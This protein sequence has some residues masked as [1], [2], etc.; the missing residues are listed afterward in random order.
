MPEVCIVVPAYRAESTL[1]AALRSVLEQS[2]RDWECVVVDDAS[3]DGTADA[4]AG[5][6]AGDPR[7][8]YSRLDSNRGPAAARNRGIALARSPWIAFLDGD[9]AWVPWRLEAGLVLAKQDPGIGLWCGETA[10]WSGAES[11]QPPARPSTWPPAFREVFLD[12]LAVH[13]PVATSTVLARREVLDSV[14]GFDEGF[15]GPEDYDLWL[16]VAGRSRLARIAA[17]LC[18]YRHRPGSLSLNDTRF[19]VEI[20]RVI[21]KAYGPAGVLAGRPGR[22]RALAYYVFSCCWMA[23]ERGDRARAM[24]LFW[25]GFWLW[26]WSHRNPYTNFRGMRTR[27]LVYV[28]RR[29]VAASGAE[30]CLP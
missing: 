5:V 19:L 27:L 24:A 29:R 21:D 7:F 12:E 11:E 18:R 9:D 25:R 16:R 10:R 13:N 15:R 30:G 2:V 1:A 22:R 14:G 3:P 6:T 20:G 4:Y 8:R 23:A 26:P 28:L 17:P